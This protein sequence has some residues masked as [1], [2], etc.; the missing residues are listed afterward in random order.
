MSGNKHVT[1]HC[2]TLDLEPQPPHKD[3]EE[4]KGLISRPS[5]GRT[6]ALGRKVER[7]GSCPPAGPSGQRDQRKQDQ[8]HTNK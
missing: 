8:K 6:T 4:P 7:P 5:S 1:E 3:S 2:D